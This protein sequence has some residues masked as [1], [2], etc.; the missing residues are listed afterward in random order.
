MSAIGPDNDPRNEYIYYL[1]FQLS[2]G[3]VA[4]NWNAGKIYLR[5]QGHVS[6]E[7]GH[8]F[9]TIRRKTFLFY[10]HCI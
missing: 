9:G 5:F 4:V 7:C 8:L 10:Q 6:A 1:P 2:P 3:A